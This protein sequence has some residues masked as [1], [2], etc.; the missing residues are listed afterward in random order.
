MTKTFLKF[1]T[2]AVLL[3]IFC[4]SFNSCKKDEHYNPERKIKR[5]Y[6]G[7]ENGVKYLQQEWSWDDNKLMRIDYYFGDNNIGNTEYYT[8]E[9]NK[10][11]KVEDVDGYFQISYSG[12]KYDKIEYFSKENDRFIGTW[13]FSYR[14]NKISKTVFKYDNVFWINKITKDGFL[15]FLIPTEIIS[16]L[17]NSAKSNIEKLIMTYKYKGTPKI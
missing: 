1:T 3:F 4:V 16:T 8:Y 5:I 10:L 7:S 11:V 13:D 9:K 6:Y 17:E 12:F 14:N 15:S 2:V